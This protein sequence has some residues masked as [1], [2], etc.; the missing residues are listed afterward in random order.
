MKRQWH[1]QVSDSTNNVHIA[2]LFSVTVT[3]SDVF[4]DSLC[5][6]TTLTIRFCVFVAWKFLLALL[7]TIVLSNVQALFVVAIFQK[8]NYNQM[9]SMWNESFFATFISW[10]TKDKNNSIKSNGLKIV[11]IVIEH[12]CACWFTIVC[13]ATETTTTKHETKHFWDSNGSML[14]CCSSTWFFIVLM[15]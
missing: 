10:A 6:I 12:R 8:S 1:T 4:L 3:R 15:S 2:F 9:F 14:Q 13:A 5:A 7:F 11:F